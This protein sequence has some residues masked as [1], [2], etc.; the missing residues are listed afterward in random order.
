MP[1]EGAP[2]LHLGDV[3]K[4]VEDHQP[5]IGDAVVNDGSSLLLVVEK[6]PGANT[7]EV[8]RGIEDTLAALK[9]GLSGL[10]MDSSI[11][12][13]A[14]FIERSILDLR[15]ALLFG[16]VLLILVLSAF[17]FEWRTALISTIVIILSLLTAVLVLYAR[18]ATMNAI[19]LAGLLMA[20]SVLVDD[21]IIDVENIM[22][23]LRQNRHEGG[24]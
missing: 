6:F 23:R 3:A 8:T 14:N 16:F 19:V 12:R 22:R 24:L 17:L 15:T 7:L 11:F 5:L 1:V 9:P 13:P 20:L 21:A 18:G 4:V 2:S 10:E